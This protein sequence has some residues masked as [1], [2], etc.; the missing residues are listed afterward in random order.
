MSTEINSRP[1]LAAGV[2]RLGG[3]APAAII[4]VALA[5]TACSGAVATTRSATPRATRSAAPGS[6][7][8]VDET[9]SG[10]VS[11]RVGQQLI[12]DLHS[13][14]WMVQGSSN[15]PVLTMDG[16]VV[17][18]PSPDGCVPGQGCGTV[19]ADFH[20]IAPGDAVVNASRTSCGEALRCTGGQG[21]FRL[22]VHVTS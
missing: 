5:L 9:A 16:A 19:T 17:V 11:L 15:P 20:A 14:Y 2:W 8:T 10:A 3:V 7:V 1:N 22:T 13:T 6:T 18:S 4:A 12:I 21:T